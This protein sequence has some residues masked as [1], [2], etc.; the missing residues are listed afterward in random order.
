M[1]PEQLTI[2]LDALHRNS[3][4]HW[5]QNPIQLTQ[6]GFLRIAEENHAFNYQLWHEEDKARRDDMGAEFVYQAKRNIDHFNQQRNNCM[7]LMDKQLQQELQPVDPTPNC[8]VNSET[9]GM[10]IDRLSI[11]TLKHYHMAVQTLRHDVDSA[12]RERCQLKLDLIESQRNQ[13]LVCLTEFL[14]AILD[15]KRTYRL[16]HQLK[17]YNDKT[18]NPELYLS[19][20]SPAATHAP[21]G[22]TEATGEEGHSISITE[23]LAE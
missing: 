9:P 11:L 1:T 16:Y 14:Q 8:P 12:H 10:I 3:I 17:M 4:T 22:A 23:V 20:E 19:G 15:K 13:L 21:K 18:L 2:E 7:E 6:Q 5:K